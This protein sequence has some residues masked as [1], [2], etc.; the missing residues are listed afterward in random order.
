ML[1]GEAAAAPAPRGSHLLL[2][3]GKLDTGLAPS[4]LPPGLIYRV[5]GG[6]VLLTHTRARAESEHVLARDQ[7]TNHTHTHTTCVLNTIVVVVML[8]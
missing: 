4:F 5:F 3:G 7:T 2:G 8:L 1:R 6:T